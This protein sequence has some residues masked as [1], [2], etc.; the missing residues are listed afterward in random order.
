MVEAPQHDA[1]RQ[2]R[3]AIMTTAD[4]CPFSTFWLTLNMLCTAFPCSMWHYDM[5]LPAVRTA[6]AHAHAQ[7]G[8]EEARKLREDAARVVGVSVRCSQSVIA[9]QLPFL[10]SSCRRQGG[11]G[12]NEL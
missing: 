8:G 4:A 6:H 2:T 12:H 9:A 7:A 10:S 3:A 11:G 1:S 5:I